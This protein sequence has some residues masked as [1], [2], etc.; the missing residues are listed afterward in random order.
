[1]IRTLIYKT[2]NQQTVLLYQVFI[3]EDLKGTFFLEEDAIRLDRQWQNENKL[4]KIEEYES[5][6]KKT[7]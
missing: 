7:P 1:M 2:V 6:K 4:D 3:D 5:Q